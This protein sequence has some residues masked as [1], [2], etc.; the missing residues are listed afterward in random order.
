[1]ALKAGT[2][3]SGTTQVAT[4]YPI[5]NPPPLLPPFFPMTAIGQKLTSVKQ[6]FGAAIP[7]G[8]TNAYV[9]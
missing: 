3:D 7:H 5:I 9:P 2:P 8:C 4:P 6:D 1:M